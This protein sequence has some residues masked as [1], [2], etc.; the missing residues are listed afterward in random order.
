MLSN[1]LIEYLPHRD[2]F[3]LDEQPITTVTRLSGFAIAPKRYARR[4]WSMLASCHFQ[5]IIMASTMATSPAFP[6]P[7]SSLCIID[8]GL[9]LNL[10]RRLSFILLRASVVVTSPSPFWPTLLPPVPEAPSTAAMLQYR[11]TSPVQCAA[12]TWKPTSTPSSTS[13]TQTPSKCG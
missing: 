2:R 3:Y 10:C 13:G 11:T 1:D 6:L 12:S 4:P 8:R 9:S 7:M 5:A